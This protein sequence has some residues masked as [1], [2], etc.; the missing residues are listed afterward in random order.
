M[1]FWHADG[2]GMKGI[3]EAHF[4]TKGCTDYKCNFLC[5]DKFVHVHVARAICKSP[6]S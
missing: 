3:C 6:N 2:P 1:A 4:N 5:F